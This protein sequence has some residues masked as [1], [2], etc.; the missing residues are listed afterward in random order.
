MQAHFHKT[1]F[2]PVPHILGAFP[3]S[4]TPPVP[5]DSEI[6][7][8]LF[9]H[10]LYLRLYEIWNLQPDERCLSEADLT[11]LSVTP[12]SLQITAHS[13]LQLEMVPSHACKLH[14]LSL[15]SMD[16]PVGRFQ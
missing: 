7:S 2:L 4:L 5:F 6:V 3:S 13:S 14:V 1:H 15:F 8:L 12:V 11:L 9:W 10:L 16:G